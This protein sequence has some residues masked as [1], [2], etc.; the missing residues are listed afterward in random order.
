MIAASSPLR[1]LSSSRNRKT[2]ALRRVKEVSRQA[3]KAAVAA[4]TVASTS[5]WEARATSP[6]TWP[7]AG[8]LTGA[9]RPLVPCRRAPS[10]QCGMGVGVPGVVTVDLQPDGLWCVSVVARGRVDDGG[11]EDTEALDL[12]LD[13]VAGVQQPWRRADVA[14]ALRGAGGDDVAGLQGEGAADQ[15]EDRAELE[16]HVPG[17]A[18]LDG[19]AVD[20]RLNSE[21]VTEVP[22]LRGRDQRAQRSAAVAVL[23]QRPLG[24][25]LLRTPRG[26][27][28]E[29]GVPE[30]CRPCGVRV[31]VAQRSSDVGGDLALPVETGLARG[32]W[33]RNAV[34]A[35]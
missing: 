12:D 24:G 15:G 19:A 33:C 35:Q 1:A 29:G 20:A 32:N 14:H 10:I 13:H 25:E 28:V 27:V 34:D 7:V 16:D 30:D 9:V 23:A 8:S 18:V 5:S 3:G 26:Q 31:D 21:S 22:Y 2:I 17:V 11:A 6:V 4:A